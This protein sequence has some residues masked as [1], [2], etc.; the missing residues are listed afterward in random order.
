M[1]PAKNTFSQRCKKY[2][3]SKLNG[4]DP[5]I[6]NNHHSC[7]LAFLNQ[8]SYLHL[9]FWLKSSSYNIIWPKKLIFWIFIIFYHQLHRDL[10][11]AHFAPLGDPRWGTPT[12]P[13]TPLPTYVFLVSNEP[14]YDI[15]SPY[16]GD[17]YNFS[18]KWV[19]GRN[20]SFWG[21]SG[22]LWGHRLNSGR[23]EGRPQGFFLAILPLPRAQTF[24]RDVFWPGARFGT[25][26]SFIVFFCILVIRQLL[27]K[28]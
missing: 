16:F 27:Y 23:L 15:R 4:Q 25:P 7:N 22:Q 8:N 12:P 6:F 13:P 3:P 11:F 17:F 24:G 1:Q 21:L 19:V 5:K 9:V 20:W 2:K 28:A 26:Q 10:N 14:T 18:K